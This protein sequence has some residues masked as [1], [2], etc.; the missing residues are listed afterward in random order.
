MRAP[1]AVTARRKTFDMPD[2]RGRRVTATQSCLA[3]VRR[4]AENSDEGDKRPTGLPLRLASRVAKAEGRATGAISAAL[5]RPITRK[6]LP[7]RPRDCAFRFSARN[8]FGCK[9]RL[10][11]EMAFWSEAGAGVSCGNVVV[12]VRDQCCVCAVLRSA[13]TASAA[14]RAPPSPPATPSGQSAP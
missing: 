4:R 2:R 7:A 8:Q 3:F 1:G 5:S 14:S 13:T 6:M 11:T 10:S 9:M 12:A